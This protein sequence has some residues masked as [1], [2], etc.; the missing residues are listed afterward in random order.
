MDLH[1]NE[2]MDEGHANTIAHET[3]RAICKRKH[4]PSGNA[5]GDGGDPNLPRTKEDLEKNRKKNTANDQSGGRLAVA[6]SGGGK[7]ALSF[8]TISSFTTGEDDHRGGGASSEV[9]VNPGELPMRDPEVRE[10]ASASIGSGAGAGAAGVLGF[11]KDMW[12]FR[13]QLWEDIWNIPA[14]EERKEVADAERAFRGMQEQQE[15]VDEDAGESIGLSEGGRSD[16]DDP[17]DTFSGDDDALE[18]DDHDAAAPAGGD[19]GT[20]AAGETAASDARL[21]AKARRKEEEDGEEDVRDEDGRLRSGDGAGTEAVAVREEQ[22]LQWRLRADGTGT[23][24]VAATGADETAAEGTTSKSP[25][26]SPDDGVEKNRQE[27]SGEEVRGRRGGASFV[28]TGMQQRR[29][30][31]ATRSEA[32]GGASFVQTGMQ[33]RQEMIDVPTPSGEKTEK[34]AVRRTTSFTEDLGSTSL[35]IAPSTDTWSSEEE[36]DDQVSVEGFD[37][38]DAEDAKTML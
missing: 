37:A 17:A 20:D 28:Q 22:Q 38:D 25:G 26:E 7:A 19:A 16:G 15:D 11:F 8:S 31:D 18:G 10:N 34:R 32:R 21:L 1:F 13:A 27:K 14:L 2:G 23:E 33:Q 5:I 6:A 30:I 9:P 24:A 35:L 29:E 3:A 36:E 12:K 4:D